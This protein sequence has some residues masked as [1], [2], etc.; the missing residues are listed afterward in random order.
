MKLAAS[1]RLDGRGIPQ[2]HAD[3]PRRSEKLIRQVRFVG[4]PH[5]GKLFARKARHREDGESVEE[6]DPNAVTLSR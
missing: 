6:Q 4:N 3:E 1:S 5:R 2:A